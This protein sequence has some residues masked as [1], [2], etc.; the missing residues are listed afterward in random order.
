MTVRATVL[1]EFIEGL[2]IVRSLGGQDF[3]AEH[4]VIGVSRY[5]RSEGRW[6][7]PNAEQAA[8]LDKLGWVFDEEYCCWR[9][10]A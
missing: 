9:T 8:R 3:S 4:E 2:E 5:H 1:D 7:R 6:L 10:C